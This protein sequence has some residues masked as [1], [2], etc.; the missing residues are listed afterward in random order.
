MQNSALKKMLAIRKST[1]THVLN[2][3][4]TV[5]QEEGNTIGFGVWSFQDGDMRTVQFM[6]TNTSI[7]EGKL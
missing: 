4:R 7:A 5:A 1:R 6:Q 2:A 3:G